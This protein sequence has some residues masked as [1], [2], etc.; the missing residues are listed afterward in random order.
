MFLQARAYAIAQLREPVGREVPIAC[1]EH[2]RK[3]V[4]ELARRQEPLRL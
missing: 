1:V 2:G 4:G 3:A